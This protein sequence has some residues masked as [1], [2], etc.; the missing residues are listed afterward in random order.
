MNENQVVYDVFCPKC[1]VKNKGTNQYCC[2]CGKL[3]NTN[4]SEKKHT[5]A[6]FI[7]LFCFSFAVFGTLGFKA[8]LIS[9]LIPLSYLI[10][11]NTKAFHKILLFVCSGLGLIMVLVVLF[12][13]G[14]FLY[15]LFSLN[16]AG[17][18]G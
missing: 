2:S 7:I 13:V 6:V 16:R 9:L 4:V 18:I 14:F 5:F 1:G 17:G 3:L 15:F 11:G 12:I 8:F 10:F